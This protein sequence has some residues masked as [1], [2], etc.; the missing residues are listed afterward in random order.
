[1]QE[2]EESLMVTQVEIASVYRSSKEIYEFFKRF[3][4]I[5]LCIIASIIAIPITVIT[6]VFVLL[7][8][9][10]NPIYSQERLGKDEKSFIIY[11]IRSMSCDAEKNGPRW[12]DK[13]D[14]RVTNIG[15]FIR[16]TRIDELPQ[17][18]N[19]LKGDMTIVGP[20][21]ERAVFTYE[22]EKTI[23]GFT[24]R[25]KVKPGLTGLAQV[26]GGYEITPKEKLYWDLKYIE[27]KNFAKDLNIILKTVVVVVTGHGAR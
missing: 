5:I 8:S 25:L 13:N 24:N 11:K 4:D 2:L 18:Y 23:P 19:I 15:K 16:K 26:N 10:G 22:F 7:E 9:K 17:L 12:A 6:C 14:E 3:T 27:E 1:M 21:P 20:R